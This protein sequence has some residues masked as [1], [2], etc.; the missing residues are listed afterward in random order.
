MAGGSVHA[1][2][3]FRILRTIWDELDR[4]LEECYEKPV[5]SIWNTLD[6]LF[7]M[8]K[9]LWRST[10]E[11]RHAIC[12]ATAIDMLEKGTVIPEGID[13]KYFAGGHANI[14]AIERVQN[15]QQL[16]AWR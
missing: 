11:R 6:R 1:G 13:G 10:S 15:K 14:L 3:W 5:L 12:V 7:E 4:P 2:L 9:A 16:S 8:A